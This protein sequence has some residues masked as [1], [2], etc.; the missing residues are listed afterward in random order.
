MFVIAGI[1]LFTGSY[2]YDDIDAGERLT[3][4]NSSHLFGIDSY[5]RDY[6]TRV[7]LGVF[8]SIG[9][10]LI[11]AVLSIAVGAPVGVYSAI[12]GGWIDMSIGRSLEVLFAFPQI[13]LALV[14]ITII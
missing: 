11:V 4:P 10:G 5:G 6:L 13:L 1:V 3:R 9:V 12:R 2:S 8:I 14:L 7:S